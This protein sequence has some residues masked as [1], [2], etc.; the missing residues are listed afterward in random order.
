[1]TPVDEFTTPEFLDDLKVGLYGKDRWLLLDPFSYVTMVR[2]YPQV[3]HVPRFY[4]TDLASIPNWARFVIP[5]N[6]YH[7]WAAIIHDFLYDSQASHNFTRKEADQIFQEAM[8]ITPLEAWKCSAMYRAVRLGAGRAWSANPSRQ[9]LTP[10]S[11][12]YVGSDIAPKGR[13]RW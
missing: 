8:G 5:V 11:M 3:I 1:M 12:L 2:G 9:G 7:R 4:V 6:D 13:Y 10:N